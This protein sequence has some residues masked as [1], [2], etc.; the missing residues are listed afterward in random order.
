MKIPKDDGTTNP[1]ND[2]VDNWKD[3]LCDKCGKSCRDGCDMNFEYALIEVNWGYGS[4]KDGESHVAQV[5][6]TCYD[7]LGIKP[8][9]RDYL[10]GGVACSCNRSNAPVASGTCGVHG[11]GE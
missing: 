6:E 9:I 8:A 4:R 11:S 7:G 10:F 2:S 1:K 5:C 3:I